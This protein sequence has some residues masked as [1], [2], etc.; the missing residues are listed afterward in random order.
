MS[1]S[2]GRISVSPSSSTVPKPKRAHQ[3]KPGCGAPMHITPSPCLRATSSPL[4]PFAA[5]RIGVSMGR[6]GAKPGGWSM[7]TALP[8]T[9]T[10][11]YKKASDQTDKAALRGMALILRDR[12]GKLKTGAAD[13][14]AAHLAFI[15]I[16]GGFLDRGARAR[17]A[18]RADELKA[19]VSKTV[20]ADVDTQKAQAAIDALFPCP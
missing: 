7:R 17:D 10:D 4:G 8:S 19:E 12:L 1:T 6:G 18:A 2:P 13:V 20:V 16:I 14:Q 11:L 3:S 15:N 5:T 9:R